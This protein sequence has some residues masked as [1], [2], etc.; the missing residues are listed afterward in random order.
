MH[1]N[2]PNKSPPD[3]YL[4]TTTSISTPLMPPQCP[5]DV[6]VRIFHCVALVF[7]SHKHKT[8]SDLKEIFIHAWPELAPS[9]KTRKSTMP[10]GC[11]GLPGRTKGRCHTLKYLDEPTDETSADRRLPRRGSHHGFPTHPFCFAL[12]RFTIP[13]K[14]YTASRCSRKKP[15]HCNF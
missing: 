2:Q 15:K 3:N 13:V 14:K 6:E 5:S 11:S 7:D 9:L 10:S 12:L 8:L 1:I 4:S